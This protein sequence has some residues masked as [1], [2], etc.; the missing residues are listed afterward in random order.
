MYAIIEMV[1]VMELE[2]KKRYQ[3]FIGIMAY[4]I[5]FFIIG[6]LL[7]QGIS[8][9]IAHN[10]G[11]SAK[12][13]ISAASKLT[14]NSYLN[15]YGAELNAIGNML[16][17]LL[18][19]VALIIIMRGFLAEDFK[20]LKEKKPLYFL[21][22]I[23]CAI[24]LATASALMDHFI[25]KIVGT[26]SDNQ[27]SITNVF[28]YKEYW[29]PM[30]LMTVIFAPVVEELVFR[31]SIFTILGKYSVWI[32]IA[33][34][35]FAFSI[36]HMTSTTS[37]AVWKWFV[38]YLSYIIC[39]LALSLIYKYSGKNIYASIFAHMLNNLVA[40]IIIIL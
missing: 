9:A 2:E 15:K 8:L 29:L 30:I 35:T 17:Y 22:F 19:F 18:L 21:I 16:V 25:P 13:I 40:V 6:T 3:S 27:S 5:G 23:L 7:I 14:D 11:Y 32:S 31:K 38:I 33:V 24:L 36:I 12:E 37:I 26:T 20:K 1:I 4:V 28:K 39:G 34:S 10:S